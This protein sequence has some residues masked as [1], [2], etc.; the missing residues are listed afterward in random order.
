MKGGPIPPVH[1]GAALVF[2]HVTLMT[3]VGFWYRELSHKLVHYE[4]PVPN[5]LEASSIHCQQQ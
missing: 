2:K 5:Q 3:S 1:T 4:H